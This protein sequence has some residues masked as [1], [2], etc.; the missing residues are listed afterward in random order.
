MVDLK[1]KQQVITSMMQVWV[2]EVNK[3]NHMSEMNI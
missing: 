1:R 3:N 2:N